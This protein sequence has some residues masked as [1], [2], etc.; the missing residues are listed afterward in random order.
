MKLRSNEEDDWFSLRVCWKLLLYFY[1]SL[2]MYFGKTFPFDNSLE[3][4]L[5]LLKMI[6]I[7]H[8]QFADNLW[9]G[10]S[11]VFVVFYEMFCSRKAL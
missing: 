10:L 8:L 1:D 5:L 4:V 6:V 9:K 11:N 2:Y 3:M 7:L